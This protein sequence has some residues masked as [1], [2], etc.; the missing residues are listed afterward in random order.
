[1]SINFITRTLA[2]AALI[3]LCALA[4]TA[5]AQTSSATSTPAITQD[6]GQEPGS[7]QIF[8]EEFTR[9]RPGGSATVGAKPVYRRVK[10]IRRHSASTSVAQKNPGKTN[11][12]SPVKPA[13]V[14]AATVDVPLTSAKIGV[15]I[16]QLRA[17]RPADSGARLLVQDAGEL[18]PVRVSSTTVLNVGDSVFLSVESPREGYLYIVDREFFS[19][20]ST[21][22]PYLIFPTTK[23]RGGDNR[24]AP[25]KLISIPDSRDAPNF[26]KLIP[27]PNR[28]DQ[29][30]EL[31]TVII[32]SQP[33]EGFTMTDQP[34]RLTAA[35]VDKWEDQ[36]GGDTD[37]FDLQGGGG[38]AWTADERDAAATGNGSRLLV[39]GAPPPQTFYLITPRDTKGILADVELR[40]QR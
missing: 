15:T 33:L 3:G 34:A 17:S 35:Q 16:W 8:A 25:G 20:G 30:G 4:Q 5:L 23:T 27:L 38:L 21:G 32:T 9:G 28:Q 10:V 24:V 11:P 12:G 13:L 7:R 19:D 18:T 29:S 14:V 39:Q 22:D 40:Y 37:E 26:F 2:V 1:V 36:W 31:L 6:P